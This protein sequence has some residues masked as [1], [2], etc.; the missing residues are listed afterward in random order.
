[1][2]LLDDFFGFFF[3]SEVTE[4]VTDVTWGDCHVRSTPLASKPV[5]LR[6]A[7]RRVTGQNAAAAVLVGAVASQPRAS[8]A[9]R[10]GGAGRLACS[11][12]VLVEWRLAAACC[13]GCGTS[14]SI[15]VLHATRRLDYEVGGGRGRGKGPAVRVR[16]VKT[17]FGWL[18]AGPARRWRACNRCSYSLF[19]PPPLSAPSHQS[20]VSVDQTLPGGCGRPA[21]ARPVR[22]RPH[23]HPHPTQPR[24]R[25]RPRR[26]A[27]RLTRAPP[28][29]PLSRTTSNEFRGALARAHALFRRGDRDGSGGLDL[30]EFCELFCVRQDKLSKKLFKLFGG[31]QRTGLSFRN[32]VL[33]MSAFDGGAGPLQ[34]MQ[35]AFRVFDED[36]SGTVDRNELLLAANAAD[37]RE[38]ARINSK[39]SGDLWGAG[40]ASRRGSVTGPNSALALVA[41]LKED[42]PDEL[43]FDAFMVVCTKVPKLLIPARA[44]WAAIAEYAAPAREFVEEMRRQRN[45]KF[46]EGAPK[47]LLQP[48]PQPLRTAPGGEGGREGEQGPPP[49]SAPMQSGGG[50]ARSATMPVKAHAMSM[51][52]PRP[53]SLRVLPRQKS[54]SHEP[55]VSSDTKEMLREALTA[56]ARGKDKSR[57]RSA[58]NETF[59]GASVTEGLASGDDELAH[60]CKQLV[61]SPSWGRATSAI[62]AIN[63]MQ[64]QA[65][66]AR[67][68]LGDD[69]APELIARTVEQEERVQRQADKLARTEREL[70]ERERGMRERMAQQQQH[71]VD[72]QR[73]MQSMSHNSRVT[74]ERETMLARAQKAQADE[75]IARQAAHVEADRR[76]MNAAKANLE[77]RE[78]E[79]REMARRG[80]GSGGGAPT[81]SDDDSTCCVCLDAP[82]NALLV[83]CGHLALCYGCAVSGGFASGQMPCP[84]CRSSCAKVVQVFNV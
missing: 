3:E 19:F 77:A 33:G 68:A 43:D 69:A 64:H 24:R 51:S 74:L 78:R 62:S 39:R 25:N 41:G 13:M 36:G 16:S 14:R 55:D 81:S 20:P 28:A 67:S 4:L 58:S 9:S 7:A 30:G 71:M 31:R 27:L 1:M 52:A 45:R 66:R 5:A 8:V 53:P 57:R 44:L 37:T 2:L 26:R 42:M 59:S 76:E 54:M 12:N 75:A 34:L 80:S 65:R 48:L 22:L 82:R 11:R 70:R 73:Q 15:E 6:S 63:R 50:R 35:F 61:S 49:G 60:V 56:A 32:F 40:S 10:R 17:L 83:P 47:G 23:P 79:L 21:L 18:L 38:L 84:V 72:M 46:F 29:R